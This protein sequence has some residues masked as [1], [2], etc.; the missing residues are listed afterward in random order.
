[1]QTNLAGIASYLSP[2]IFYAKIYIE[3]KFAKGVEL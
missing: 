3:I 1:M 2:S